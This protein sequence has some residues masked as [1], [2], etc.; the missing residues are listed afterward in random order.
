MV[1]LSVLELMMS[2]LVELHTGRLLKTL[3]Y[4]EANDQTI[5]LSNIPATCILQHPAITGWL[6]LVN[7]I[8]WRSITK[9]EAVNKEWDRTMKA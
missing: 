9:Q 3:A 2:Y 7:T 8:H 6:K 4:S 5:M 1:V